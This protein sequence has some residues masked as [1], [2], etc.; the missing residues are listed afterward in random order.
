MKLFR[1][2][3]PAAIVLG[4]GLAVGGPQTGCG[5]FSSNSPQVTSDV[6]Q[7]ASCVIAQ[8][9]QGVTD[10]LKIVSA[11]V[12]ATLA[13]VEQIIA[14]IINYYDQPDAA[15][16]DAHPGVGKPPFDKLPASVT[17]AQLASFKQLHDQT[18]AQ[19]AGAK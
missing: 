10:P 3:A 16:G 11:C 13:D 7:I 18:K 14:S 1:V 2:F 5:W 12:P 17:S 6:G 19:M 15:V 4:L 8:M 9:F